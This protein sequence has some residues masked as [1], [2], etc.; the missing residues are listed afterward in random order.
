MEDSMISFNDQTIN[1]DHQINTFV[2]HESV[3]TEE[4][5]RLL[6]RLDKII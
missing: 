1:N 2:I 4:P 3:V 5:S 6:S